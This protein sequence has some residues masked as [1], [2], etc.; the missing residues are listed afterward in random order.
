[1]VGREGFSGGGV[2]SSGGGSDGGGGGGGRG[3]GILW[4]TLTQR[5]P[6]VLFLRPSTTFR[7]WNC[8]TPKCLAISST[9]FHTLFTS[10]PFLGIWLMNS[11]ATISRFGANMQIK[12]L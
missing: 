1:M 2:G 3:G 11:F 10:V 7:T 8:G 12:L 9:E 4:H 5:K 6:K